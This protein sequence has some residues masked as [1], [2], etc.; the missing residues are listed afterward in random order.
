[1]DFEAIAKAALDK[2]A[3]LIAEIRSIEDDSTLTEAEKRERVEKI[4]VDVKACE[5]EARSAVERGERENEV[6]TLAQ[7][8]SGLFVP[9]KPEDKQSEDAKGALSQL[10][11]VATGEA[12]EAVFDL[13]EGEVALRTAVTGTVGNAGYA[14][15][16]T[17]FVAELVKY[18][19]ERSN[20]LS[21]ARVMST[22]GGELI[23]I[24]RR[25]TVPTAAG[26][27]AENTAIS[28]SDL[29]MDRIT[30]SAYKYGVIGEAT[31]EL[32]EDE[33]IGFASLLAQD[34]GEVTADR[35]NAALM[36]GTGSSQPT[37]L[38]TAAAA[39]VTGIANL[40]AVGFDDLIS[41]QHSVA[42]PYR[43]N[44]AFWMNDALVASLRK[45]KDSQGQ[46]LWQPSV[47]AGRADTVIGV[48]V[49]TDPNFA[50]AGAS[51]KVA[52]YGDAGR[53]TVRQ[54]R[55]LQV[56]RSD[57]YGWDKDVVAFKVTWRGDGNLLDPNAVKSL[58]VT[59]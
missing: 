23:E 19:R 55:S 13:L 35:I 37:G 27:I 52:L 15:P 58:T 9:G 46:Y 54:V 28:K 42:V 31:V 51:A 2:R 16:S 22:S 14:H 11:A 34:L 8:A 6:R 1:M 3:N 49:Y 57:E 36:T 50:V 29:G 47:Q 25:I 21:V 56:S 12:R 20:I 5:D 26:P 18:M 39:G 53:Y 48:P 38:I 59:A 44:G 40:A 24:P 45:K 41:L 33:Q 43:A 4:D 7:R 10:R 32:L 17:T 30:M